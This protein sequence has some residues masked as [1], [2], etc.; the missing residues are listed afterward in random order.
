MSPG[1]EAVMYRSYNNDFNLD[2]DEKEETEL[3]FET[4]DVAL[5]RHPLRIFS[6]RHPPRGHDSTS[7]IRS[8]VL[9]NSQVADLK[10]AY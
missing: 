7:A 8:S 3:A 10:A 5:G 2:L 4:F 6:K 9:L 1:K